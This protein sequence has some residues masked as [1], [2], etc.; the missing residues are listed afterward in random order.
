MTRL[1]LGQVVRVRIGSSSV[2]LAQT[3]DSAIDVSARVPETSSH[4]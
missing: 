4:V 2:D 3:L 1:T